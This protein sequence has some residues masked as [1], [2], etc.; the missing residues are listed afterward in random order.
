MHVLVN[1][2]YLPDHFHH[3]HHQNIHGRSHHLGCRE[4]VVAAP[5]KPPMIPNYYEH[6]H[7]HSTCPSVTITLCMIKISCIYMC[8]VE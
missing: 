4:Q 3:L 2:I 7:I 5:N 6:I 8:S 1:T